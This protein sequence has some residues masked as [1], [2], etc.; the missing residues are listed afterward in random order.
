[1]AAKLSSTR[2]ATAGAGQD[3][4]ITP[5]PALIPA[6]NLLS[7]RDEGLQ[8]FINGSLKPDGTRDDNGVTD[9]KIFFQT[10]A[11]SGN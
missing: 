9:I 10:Y 11:Y 5:S 8:R 6:G 3:Y 4:T 7:D 2:A 1:M